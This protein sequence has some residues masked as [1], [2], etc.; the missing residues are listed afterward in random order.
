MVPSLKAWGLAFLLGACVGEAF[1]FTHLKFVSL[2]K[3]SCRREELSNT[4]NRLLVRCAAVPSGQKKKIAVIGSGAVGLYY[5]SRLAEAG[6]DVS[7]LCRQACISC[8]SQIRNF[9]HTFVIPAAD[10]RVHGAVYVSWTESE[11]GGSHTCTDSW[12][13]HIDIHDI[14]LITYD[15]NESSNFDIMTLC[16]TFGQSQALPIHPHS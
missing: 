11:H 10:I 6:H 12:C 4:R 7:F 15:Q 8:A 2:P 14:T 13:K 5:G 16:M 9:E 3:T 1:V